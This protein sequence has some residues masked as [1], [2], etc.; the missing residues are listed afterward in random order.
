MK[1]NFNLYALIM[2][3]LAVIVD[4]LWQQKNTVVTTDKTTPVLDTIMERKS[5][6]Q[7]REEAV[8]RETLE[9]LVKAGMAAPTAGNVQPWEMIVI[10][11]KDIL[12]ELSLVQPYASMAARAPAAIVVCGN[13]QDYKDKERLRDYW[14]QDTSAATENIL[15]AAEGLKLGAVW[16]G[17][18]PEQER[19]TKVQKILRLPDY[20]VPLNIIVIGHPAG[21]N[22]PKDKWKAE[23]LHWNNW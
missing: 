2:A 9:V 3:L 16:L 18:Y 23:R 10:D 15:L 21:E 5:V 22:L 1:S 4:L 17:I 11:D 19:V 8:S 13:M 14:V 20:L 12:K 7:Y 6:R